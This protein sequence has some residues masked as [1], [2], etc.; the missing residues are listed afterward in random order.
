MQEVE[1]Y[2]HIKMWPKGL[3]GNNGYMT[4]QIHREPVLCLFCLSC[5]SSGLSTDCRVEPTVWHPNV[6]S[7]SLSSILCVFPSELVLINPGKSDAKILPA[8]EC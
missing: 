1:M 4:L 2:S 7:H 5:D 3:S 6:F 8:L